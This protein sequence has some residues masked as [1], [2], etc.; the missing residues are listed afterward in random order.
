MRVLA[1]DAG[2]THIGMVEATV[3]GAGW[4]ELDVQAAHCIDLASV[5]HLRVP[6]ECCRL[7]HDNTLA[8][9]FAHFLQEYAAELSGADH[10]LV[11]QQPPGSAGQ[12]FEQLLLFAMRDKT[13]TVHPRSVHAFFG[14]GRMDYDARKRA[15]ERTAAPLLRGVDCAGA[16]RQHDIADA[17]C[18]LLFEAERRR[19]A[20]AAAAPPPRVEA[21]QQFAFTGP[22]PGRAPR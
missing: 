5:P 17:V 22:L 19:R 7:R 6:R 15:A 11:E 9:R 18:I 10:I 1:F 21:L 8:D 2:I 3:Q 20:A 13:T 16:A 4:R 12:V 14:H